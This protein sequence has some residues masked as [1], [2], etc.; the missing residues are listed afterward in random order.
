MGQGV[1]QR[2]GVS[3]G[4]EP[5]LDNSAVGCCSRKEDAAAIAFEDMEHNALIVWILGVPVPLPVPD[6]R[7][8]LN[9]ALHGRLTINGHGSLRKIGSSGPVP[10]SKLED[11]DM[12]SV[13]PFKLPPEFTGKP[14]SLQFQFPGKR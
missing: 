10:N 2:S 4:G 9:C 8:D 1:L 12:L 7:V 14:S 6:V 13:G 11:A 3:R 5:Y